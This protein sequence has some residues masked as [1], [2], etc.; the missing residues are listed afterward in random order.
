MK[1]D[2]RNLTPLKAL[3]LLRALDGVPEDWRGHYAVRN[4]RDALADFVK[5]GL[6]KARRRKARKAPR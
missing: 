6:A 5:Y 3:Y 2:G 4:T 1:Y